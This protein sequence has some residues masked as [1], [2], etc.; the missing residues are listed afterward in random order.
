MTDRKSIRAATTRRQ[1]L[2]GGAAFALGSL[3]APSIVG[4]QTPVL[5]IAGWGGTWDE[6]FKA[7]IVPGFEE[8]HGCKVEIDTGWPFM[9]KLLSSSPNRPFYDILL[10]NPHDHWKALD[11]NMVEDSYSE[12][13]VPNLADIYGFSKRD[14]LVGITFLNSAVGLGYRKDLVSAPPTSWTDMFN[15][16]YAGRRGSYVMQNTLGAGFFL[17]LGQIYGDGFTDIDAMFEALERLKPMRLADFTGAMEQLMLSEEVAIAVIDDAGILKYTGQDTPLGFAWPEEG[18]VALEQTYS[19]TSGSGV[20]DLAYA[21]VNH[22]L[23]PPV[24][25]VLTEEM[26]LAPVNTRTE[27]EP[28]YADT[29]YIGEDKVANLVTP[30]WNWY[31]QNFDRLNN[32]YMRTLGG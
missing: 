8:T 3:A 30:D 5:K 4:A 27:L 13:D 9:P 20:K 32:Q 6:V 11:A 16:D 29:L 18:S 31:N 19:V 12:T 26:W 14:E 25:K 15:E 21:W 28:V 2:S 10:A 24:Q 7:S 22:V 23:S 17:M 1:V